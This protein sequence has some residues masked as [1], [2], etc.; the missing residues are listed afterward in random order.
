L[1]L[2]GFSLV[3]ALQQPSFRCNNLTRCVAVGG[4]PGS[5]QNVVEAIEGNFP[6]VVVKG[7]GRVA[8]IICAIR[9]RQSDR[10]VQNQCKG[11]LPPAMVDGVISNAY[12]QSP[13]SRFRAHQEMQRVRL[14]LAAPA[15]LL[16][17]CRSASPQAGTRICTFWI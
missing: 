12:L 8:D 2:S 14:A 1:K 3:V 15:A 6:M 5:L 7:S 16:L 17:H 13:Q 11:D 9:E 4:G 10:F